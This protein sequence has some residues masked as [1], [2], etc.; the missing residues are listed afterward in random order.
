MVG[1]PHRQ[2][3]SALAVLLRS[4]PKQ[5]LI[6]F[7]AFSDEI[8]QLF[9][10]LLV[11]LNTA[12]RHVISR[13]VNEIN[14][15]GMTALYDAIILMIEIT[16]LVLAGLVATADDDD[17]A[18]QILEKTLFRLV[19]VTDGKNTA[20]NTR[21]R[22]VKERVAELNR[23]GGGD[24]LKVI[25]IGVG[26]SAGPVLQDIANHGG[27]MV[28][29]HHAHDAGSLG[30]IFRGIAEEVVYFQQQTVVRSVTSPVLRGQDGLLTCHGQHG[31]YPYV[32]PRDDFTCDAPDCRDSHIPVNTMAYSC[33]MCNVDVCRS[34]YAGQER[35][36]VPA[37]RD[38]SIRVYAG[39][40][41]G[42]LVYPGS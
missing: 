20:G 32:I 28:E 15:Q 41:D 33:R 2:A 3:A 23:Q 27:D 19:L 10:Q 6:K 24:M 31:L 8:Y 4:L 39:D 34:C 37:H 38:D 16:I 30:P 29:Y 13:G 5:T 17:E 18:L 35:A 1:N 9:G 11:P 25:L 40:P 7:F 21:L 36:L 12:N 22:H 42:I 26:N 14:P